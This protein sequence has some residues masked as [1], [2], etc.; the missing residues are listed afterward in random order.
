MRLTSEERLK[1]RL[2]ALETLRNTARSMKGIE[3]AR[4]L[5][6]PPAEV[7]RYI[8]TGDITP[9]VRRSIEIL[10]L[11]K[12]FVPEEITIQKEWISKVLETIESEERR[13]P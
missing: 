10:K 6:V 8:S 5:K 13:R 9:S 2:L 11:F 12:R 4:A 1:L 7:S 3:I